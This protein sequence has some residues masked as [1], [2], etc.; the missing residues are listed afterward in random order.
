MA[1]TSFGSLALLM[2]L[3][4]QQFMTVSRSGEEAAVL[5]TNILVQRI[6]WELSSP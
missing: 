3:M 4:P 2:A 5:S 6:H 1:D